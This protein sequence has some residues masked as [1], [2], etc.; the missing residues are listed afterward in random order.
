M[1]MRKAVAEMHFKDPVILDVG[2]CRFKTS[3]STLCRDRGS[4]LAAM[5]SGIGFD[6]RPSEDGG[7]FIDR[8]GTHF[9]YILNYLRGC[10]DPDG[11][12][13]STLKEL[14]AE[15]DFYQLQGLH[16]LLCPPTVAVPPHC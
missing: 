2:G 15:A 12:S 11:L 13:D 6:M 10:F 14:A 3:I 16:M 7:F 8:D 4:M 9:R 5:F 1:S